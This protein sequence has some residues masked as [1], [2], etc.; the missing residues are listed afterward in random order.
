MPIPDL[1]LFVLE[2]GLQLAAPGVTG[3]LYVAGPGLSRGYLGHAGLS[4]ERFVACPFGPPGAR[5]YRTG[6][7]ARW[8]ADATLRY[9]GRADDQVKVRGFRIE[10]GEIEAALAACAGVGQAA[11]VARPD[12]MGAYG[13]WVSRCRPREPVRWTAGQC[14]GSWPRRCPSTWSRRP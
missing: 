2:P 13:W 14:G 12:G 8:A 6:D 4:A 3:E 11:V 10:L 9:V 1:D 5:M 7:L